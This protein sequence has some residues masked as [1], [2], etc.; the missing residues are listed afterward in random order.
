[1]LLGYLLCSFVGRGY[2]L[3]NWGVFVPVLPEAVA[4]PRP[5]SRLFV[6]K[7]LFVRFY[8]RP[9]CAALQENTTQ[10]REALRRASLSLVWQLK[11]L[12]E[13]L[14]QFKALLAFALFVINKLLNHRKYRLNCFSRENSNISVL[15]LRL[16]P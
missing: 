4:R 12:F 15:P 6:G 7:R 8:Q 13:F 14:V 10:K 5:F 16:W 1:L 9:C 3:Y 11:L 2:I